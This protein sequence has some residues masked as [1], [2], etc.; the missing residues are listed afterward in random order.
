MKIILSSLTFILFLSNTIL[1]QVSF[2]DVALSLGVND[3][4]AGQG[5]VFLDVNND[6]LLDIFLCNNNNQ[7][8]L[9]IN[10]NALS[11]SE[12]SASWNVNFTGPGRGVSAADFNNDGLI[13]IMIGNYNATLILY[14]NNTTNFINFT[15]D[16]GV[17]FTSWGGSINWFDYNNDGK[18][19]AA[20][21]NDGVPFHY[22][23]LF[24]NDNLSSFTNVVY[25]SGLTDSASTLCLASADYDNDGDLDL[26]CGTQTVTS[27]NGT[28][29]LY[30]N[31]G[32]GSFT[33]V[34][35]SAGMLSSN[36]CWGA[37]WG[38]YDNDGDM[39]IYLANYT[40]LNQLYRNNGDGTFTDV[41]VSSG[42][43]DAGQSFSCGWFD[44]D[45]DA[46]LDLYV[47]KSSSS[48]DRLYQ[49]SGGNFVDVAATV[50]TNDTR[51]S[52]CI[53]IGDYDNNG[54]LDVYLVN[55]G[56]ENR[57][58][59]NNAGNNNKWIVLRLIGSV[60]NRS[61]V[62]TRVKV[63]TGSVKQIREV[64]GGSGGKGQNSLPVEFGLGNVSNIDSL[65][66]RWPSGTVQNFT[67]VTPNVIYNLTEGGNLVSIEPI[68]NTE[69]PNQITLYQNYPNPFNPVTR[70]K[71]SIPYNMER[72]IVNGRGDITKIV[73]YNILG[74]EI[75]T[76]INQELQ[77]GTY[78]V[79]WNGRNQ[80]SGIYFYRLKVGS[81]V[82]TKAMILIK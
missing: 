31:N 43:N 41:A 72:G 19:D 27:G 50:G 63:V 12:S 40:G 56:T 77:P 35:L 65:I 28:L 25:S 75:E 42:M 1:S 60:S 14:K 13:D 7:N 30:R 44:Y 39:D 59:K 3:G 70:I 38:D 2:T 26:F 20:F 9:W 48:V 36:Y 61:A 78:E 47:A 79:E 29:W 17:N 45:N 76:F 11:F 66:V 51:H 69:L 10:V 52:S 18:I 64:Q 58:Y 67:N 74:G 53:S 34:T 21:A 33:N 37:D 5:V 4:G 49:N 22:N 46:D 6:G 32:N 23:Y 82:I 8:K 68:I 71:F 55:N 16:A 73:V 80:S 57:L 81:V 62:G 24:R 15:T 54:F